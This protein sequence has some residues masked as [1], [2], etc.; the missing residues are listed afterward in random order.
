MENEWWRKKTRRSTWRPRCTV[1]CGL[2][3]FIFHS[4]LVVAC[5]ASY[6]CAACDF[7]AMRPSSSSCLLVAFNLCWHQN[8]PKNRSA[9]LARKTVEEYL[10]TCECRSRRGTVVPPPCHKRT[11][12]ECEDSLASKLKTTVSVA[13]ESCFVDFPPKK[14][15]FK[16]DF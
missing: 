12:G 10:S 15:L 3:L 8:N 14:P 6:F 2:F 9:V 13:S 7:D 5:G 1:Q 4:D 16:N 11:C